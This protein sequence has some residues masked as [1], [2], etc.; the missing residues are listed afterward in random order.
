MRF[1]E[2]GFE[3]NYEEYDEELEDKMIAASVAESNE[4]RQA[5]IKVAT[6]HLN[7]EVMSK[8]LVVASSCWHWPFLTNKMKLDKIGEAY[9][10][11]NKR[12]S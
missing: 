5:E 12:V 3:D 7:C 9:D 1:N 2:S 4:I 10:Y 8:A 11:L 6:F